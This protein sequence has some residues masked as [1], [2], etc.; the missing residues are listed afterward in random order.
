MR[1]VGSTAAVFFWE[2][3]ITELAQRAQIDQYAYRRNLLSDPLA[4]RVLDAAAQA[5]GWGSSTDTFRGIAF[6]C[7]IGR[8]G[9]FKTY[10]AQVAELRRVAERFVV[11]RVFCAV[12]AGL[13]VNPNTLKAQIEGGI[14]FAMTNT[15]KS[16]VTF[17][18]GGA[19]QSNFYDYPLLSIDEMPVIVPIV[20]ASE[21]PP[22][23]AG[24]VVLAPVAPAIAQA[25]LHATGRRLDVMPFPDDVFR[26]PVEGRSGP[27]PGR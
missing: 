19:D 26:V 25:L 17:S 12:D 10:V 23:G 5:S 13:V 8:G 15:L 21:R 1:S 16:K 7:Y 22:Q 3:F 4:L 18:N 20:L 6:N 27:R 9:R 11:E 14:G 24:E 2:S